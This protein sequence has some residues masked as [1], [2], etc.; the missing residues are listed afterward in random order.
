MQAG[1]LDPMLYLI[2]LSIKFGPDQNNTELFG[3]IWVKIVAAPL[4]GAFA[5]GN[6][7]LTGK[8]KVTIPFYLL[9]Y[10]ICIMKLFITLPVNV[11]K[12]HAPVLE[13]PL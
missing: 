12:N 10:Y 3:G 6:V 2:K 4:V 5:G 9:L 7:R 13:V 1:T 11:K 8:I